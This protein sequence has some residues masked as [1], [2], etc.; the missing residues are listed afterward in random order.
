MSA[1]LLKLRNDPF[2]LYVHKN[3]VYKYMYL[4]KKVWCVTGGGG[5][6]GGQFIARVTILALV[7]PSLHNIS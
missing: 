3:G 1:T 6:E 2:A 7:L 4:L 5:G